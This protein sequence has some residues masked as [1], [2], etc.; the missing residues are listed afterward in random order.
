MTET[1]TLAGDDSEACPAGPAPPALALVIAW[2]PAEPDRVGEVAI[3]PAARTPVTFTLGRGG[4]TPDDG[5]RRLAFAR[6]RAG[7]IEERPALAMATLSRQQLRIRASGV[8]SLAVENVGRCRLAHNGVPATAAEVK[9]GDTLLLGRELLLVCVKR[10]AW[11][12]SADRVVRMAF[13]SADP[14]GWVGESPAAWEF[15]RQVAFL[16]P[17]AGHVLITGESGTGKEHAARAL[18]AL[19]PRARMPLLARNAAT[20]PESLVDAELFGH[21]RNYPNA[22]MPERLGLV[23]EAA[24]GTLFLDEIAELP[25]GLQPHLLRLLDRGEYQRL[26]DSVVRTSDFRLLA[27]TNGPD[28]L[29]PDLRA[30]FKMSLRVPGLDER[31]E[32]VPLLFRHL[33]RV[34]AGQSPDVASRLFARGDPS[35]EP[36]VT[37]RFVDALVRHRYTTH[38]RELEG[39]IWQALTRGP[40]S[41]LDG[42]IEIGR[43][44]GHA[45]EGARSPRAVAP[46]SLSPASIENA[47]LR[48]DGSVE[49][50]WRALGLGS[51]HV[52]TRLMA[53]HGL[54]RVASSKRPLGGG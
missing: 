2:S 42:P 6:H 28:R 26:G 1:T 23:A 54:R 34:I 16:A 18:H 11:L 41:V 47:L 17:Q 45:A 5:Q 30:R 48:H 20:F 25:P 14:Y 21:A 46:E 49:R 4:A 31:V 29:R 51:R 50:A 32:D 43:V 38:V 9:P 15:R 12:P 37:L 3:V 8:A 52:L 35:G 44:E 13:G 19:S 39:R 7:A 40:E 36:R 27:A 24:A 22:G 33:L 53:K 10:P